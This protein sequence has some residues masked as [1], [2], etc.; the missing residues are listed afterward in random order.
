MITERLASESHTFC[1]SCPDLSTE[2]GLGIQMGELDESTVYLPLCQMWGYRDHLR[3]R[4]LWDVS[5]GGGGRARCRGETGAGVTGKADG[6]TNRPDGGRM[7]RKQRCGCGDVRICGYV[8]ILTQEPG[9]PADEGTFW[10]LYI[11]IIFRWILHRIGF[12]H[13]LAQQLVRGFWPWTAGQGMEGRQGSSQSTLMQ[14][15]IE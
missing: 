13:Q 3:Q 12:P 11:Y 10:I 7:W 1:G 15:N 5:G 9:E 8:G 6:R 2:R 4:G 14:M